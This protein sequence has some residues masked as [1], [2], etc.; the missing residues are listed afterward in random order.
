M[1]FFF[2]ISFLILRAS[3]DDRPLANKLL[4]QRLIMNIDLGR[5]L[6]GLSE[7]VLPL[8]LRL[9]GLTLAAQ[10]VILVIPSG[11]SLLAVS[12]M[13]WLKWIFF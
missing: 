11:I 13:M 8:F 3:V 12:E 6:L 9:S 5:C 4:Q 7:A 1:S 10:A 2:V